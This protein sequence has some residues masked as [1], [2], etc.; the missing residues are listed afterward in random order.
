MGPSEESQAEGTA[1]AKALGWD[2]LGVFKKQ[3]EGWCGCGKV[4]REKPGT[5]LSR[6]LI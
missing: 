5:R 1:N 6:R 4:N 2:K 3:K